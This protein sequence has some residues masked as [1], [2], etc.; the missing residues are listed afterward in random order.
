MFRCWIC[1][2]L[3]DILITIDG[4][5]WPHTCSDNIPEVKQKLKKRQIVIDEV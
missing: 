4:E 2:S 5:L 1:K 3:P